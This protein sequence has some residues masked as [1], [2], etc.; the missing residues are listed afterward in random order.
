[1]LAAIFL[2]GSLGTGAELVLLEHTDG[3]WQNVPLALIVIGCLGIGML[4]LRP[5]ALSLR[6]FQATMGL[7]VVSGGAGVLLHYQGNVEFE[8]EL[9]PDAVGLEL[10]WEAMT[11]ATPALAPGAMIVLGAVG[12]VYAYRHPC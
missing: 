4:A 8:L 12:L 9:H 11:G 7:F 6:A 1:M 5:G 10:F 3:I 2:I